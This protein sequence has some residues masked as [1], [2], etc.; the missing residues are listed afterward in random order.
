TARQDFFLTMIELAEE[1]IPNNPHTALVEEVLLQWK[2][3][4]TKATNP[5]P[6]KRFRFRP[7]DMK[8]AE[9]QAARRKEIIEEW[10]RR[11][12]LWAP[13]APPQTGS[14]PMPS[15]SAKN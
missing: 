9:K 12:W 2:T 7:S 15:T 4:G 11:F 8:E 3:A 13:A 1:Q 6:Y 5:T 14:L 10:A